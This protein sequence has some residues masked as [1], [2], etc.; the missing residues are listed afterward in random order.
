LDQFRLPA[1]GKIFKA[2]VSLQKK[3][4]LIVSSVNKVVDQLV[5]RIIRVV[6]VI[7]PTPI[8]SIA[9]IYHPAAPT[10]L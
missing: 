7:E 5:S 2:Q 10:N 9:C 6:V 3:H 4:V 1:A 8:H